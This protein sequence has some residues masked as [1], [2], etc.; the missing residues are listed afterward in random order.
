M[1]K[2]LKR[3]LLCATLLFT[4]CSHSTAFDFF[5]VDSYYEKAVSNMKKASLMNALE[6]KAL[7]HAVYLN[8][9]DPKTYN[10]GEY[11]FVSIYIIEDAFDPKKHGLKNLDYRLQML[12]S[13]VNQKS[14]KVYISPEELTEL[15]EDHVLRRTMPIQTNWSHYYLIKFPINNDSQVKLSFEND[16]YGKVPLVFPKEI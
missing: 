15:E 16:R 13:D 3:S 9:V 5:S 2:I 7:L 14:K 6:T 1:N 8:N 4:G 11:F 10:D 12:S